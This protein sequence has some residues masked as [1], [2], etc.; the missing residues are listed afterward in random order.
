[1]KSFDI[2]RSSAAVLR[3]FTTSIGSYAVVG[4]VLIGSATAAAAALK[5]GD[6]SPFRAIAV[7]VLA[8]VEK[9][10]LAG[11]TKR[12]K[13]LEIAWDGA[14]AGLKPRAA[15]DWHSEDKAIDRV[16]TE[17]R[18]AAANATAGALSLELPERPSGLIDGR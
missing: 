8:L 13:D 12:I 1:M 9:A 5:L 6:L 15:G 11:P 3:A 2:S 14:E 17:L 4:S 16:L 10:D 18:A 7:D